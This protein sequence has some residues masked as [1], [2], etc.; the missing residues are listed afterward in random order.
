MD[1]LAYGRM[2]PLYEA[3]TVCST[4]IRWFE[5]Q[6]QERQN[7]ALQSSLGN[8]VRVIDQFVTEAST[9][10]MLAGAP[11]EAVIGSIYCLDAM[12]CMTQI[13]TRQTQA[14]VGIFPEQLRGPISS[15]LQQ[16]DV[17]TERVE[18]ILEAWNVSVDSDLAPRLRSTLELIDRSKKGIPPWREALELI[19]D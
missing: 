12:N 19:H 8:L 6:E 10:D 1:V 5:Q 18:E 2:R 13:I 15:L 14:N 11:P 7:T 9:T 3:M 4:T 16:V 17:L